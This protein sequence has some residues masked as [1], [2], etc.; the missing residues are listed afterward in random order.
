MHKTLKLVTRYDA[1]RN[2]YVIFRH[3]LAPEEAREAVQQRSAW[4]FGLFMLD[5]HTA[6]S[7]GEA[8]LCEACHREV[9][10]ISDVQPKPQFKRRHE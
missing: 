1:Q 10:R 9:E 4:L 5:R 3:N 7:A 8:E 6:H 2:E